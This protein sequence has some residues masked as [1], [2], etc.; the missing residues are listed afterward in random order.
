MDKTI[1]IKE[2]YISKFTDFEKTLNGEKTSDFHK[3]RKDAISKFETTQRSNSK[4]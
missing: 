4:R 1:D 2:W 3:V